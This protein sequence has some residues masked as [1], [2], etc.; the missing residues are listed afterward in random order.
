MLA[1]I[2]SAT[3]LGI[4]ACEVIVEVDVA[5]GL[6]HWTI[7]GLASGAVKE[8]RERVVAALLNSGF[9]LP[10]RRVTVNLAPADL[11]K[12]SSRFDLPIALALLVATKQI[13]NCLGRAAAVG[14]LALDGAIR[15]VRGVLPIARLVGARRGTLLVPMENA[16]EASL[17][18]SVT[19]GAPKT[20]REAVEQLE[21]GHFDCPSPAPVSLDRVE[22]GPDLADVVGQELARRA[23]EIASAGDHGLVLIGPPGSGKTLLARCM[24]GILPRLLES[25]SLEVI[26]VHSVAGLLAGGVSVSPDRPFRAPHHTVSIAGLVGGGSGPRPGEVSLAHRGVLFLDELLE[27]PRH[28]LDAMRQPLEDGHVTIVRAAASVRFPAQFTL[29]GAANPCNCGFAGDGSGRCGC[30]SAEIAKYRG[31]ISGPLAD[32]IDLH[33]NVSAVPVRKLSDA[34]PRENSATVRERVEFARAVQRRRYA[35]MPGDVWNGRVP[36]RWLDRNGQFVPAA[37]DFLAAAA[38]QMGV[39]ARGFHRI[40]RVARTI[41]DLDGG[42]LIESRHVAEAIRYRPAAMSPPFA[43][44]PAQRWREPIAGSTFDGH[45]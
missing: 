45:Q 40:L 43:E 42:I 16:T 39:S 4:D 15:P 28:T 27:F 31:R 9:T 21:A 10:A 22:P 33:V 41:A 13:S 3:V 7:V 38:E 20:L 29:V 8:S 37:R 19:I 24:P 12:A 6:P 32:R 26:A 14:E 2:R 36:G 44:S 11:P 17:V 25:E 30:S 5:P 18:S 35:G 34:D 23:L 1:S